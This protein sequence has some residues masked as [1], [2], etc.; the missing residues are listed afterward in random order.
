MG[1]KLVHN[2]GDACVKD[3]GSTWERNIMRDG[4]KDILLRKERKNKI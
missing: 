2:K 4:K 1:T 3:G